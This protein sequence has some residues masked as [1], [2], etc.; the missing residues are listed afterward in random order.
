M[1]QEGEIG[2]EEYFRQKEHHSRQIT[3]WEARTSDRAKIHLE[4]TTSMEMVKRV[5]QFWDITADEDRKLLAHSLFDEITYDLDQHRITDFKIKAWAEPFII[6]RAALY[7][8]E[9]GGEMKNRFNSGVSSDGSFHD[10]NGTRTR[11]YTL[12]GCRPNR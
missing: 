3:H 6:L 11:V 7:E 9:M 4:L 10:P 1:F 5:K 12:K 8:D 2:Q